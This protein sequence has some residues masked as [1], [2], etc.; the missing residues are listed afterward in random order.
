MSQLVFDVDDAGEHTYSV[1]ELAAAV[2]G[3]LQRGFSDGVWIR[4][5]IQGWSERGPH[6][7][8]RLAETVDGAK[9]VL[10]VQFFANVR[11]RLRPLLASHGVRLAEG[12]RVRIFGHLDFYAP[13]GQLG[14]KMVDIDPRFT[15]GELALQRDDLLRRLRDSGLIDANRQRPLPSV[16]L[17]IG[18]VTSVDSAAWADFRHEIE[19]SGLGFRLLLV[20]TRVQGDAAPAQLARSIGALGRRADLDAVVVIRGG[21]ARSELATFDH[22]AVALAIARCPL[23]V[24]TGLGH[25]TDRSVADEVAHLALKTPTACAGALVE[26]VGAAWASA[27]EHWSAITRAAA[28]VVRERSAEL[29]DLASTIAHRTTGAVD[30]A[31]ERLAGRVARLELAAP[32]ALER[33]ERRLV[34]AAAAVRRVPP[35]VEHEARHLE[36]LAARVRLLDPVHTMA[37]GWSITRTA[38][39]SVVRDAS[40][41]APGAEIVTTFASGSARSTVEEVR[42]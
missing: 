11:A 1:G 2:N 26:R 31:G 14:L 9:A 3:V 33:S 30:R 19:R 35:R 17:R 8:F 13:S 18:V 24:L 16:P 21:G 41:L 27:E 15:L 37:R 34:L 38:E 6:A 28:A 10:N 40:A 12:M 23:P 42:P 22:E 29:D 32:T 39:G 25:E 4:G 36:G 7:Y 5:E 20:D